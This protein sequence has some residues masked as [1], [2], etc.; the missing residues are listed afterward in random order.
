LNEHQPHAL[1]TDSP[2]KDPL[3]FLRGSIATDARLPRDHKE[4]RLTAQ[5]EAD[6]GG[7]TGQADRRPSRRDHRS[8]AGDGVARTES[9]CST[10]KDEETA[11][12]I[13]EMLDRLDSQGAN[14][15]DPAFAR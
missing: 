2:T 8:C 10:E 6:S 14:V 12:E 11:R 13:A 9:T 3:R 4:R 1:S 7:F 15:P 5:T